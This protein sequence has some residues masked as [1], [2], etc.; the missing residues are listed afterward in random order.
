M[1]IVHNFE[2]QNSR[3]KKSERERER[4]KRGKENTCT[5]FS[6]MLIK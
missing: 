5:L 4:K 2:G 6:F 3:T 1:A